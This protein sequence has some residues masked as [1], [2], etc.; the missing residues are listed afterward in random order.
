MSSFYVSAPR[1]VNNLNFAGH[2]REPMRYWIVVIQSLV[3]S[4]T[5]CLLQESQNGEKGGTKLGTTIIRFDSTRPRSKDQSQGWNTLADKQTRTLGRNGKDCT[6]K[7]FSISVLQLE[8]KGKVNFFSHQSW[9]GRYVEKYR[10][11]FKNISIRQNIAQKISI[12]QYI[13]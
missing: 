1:D 9:P 10:Y 2:L 3:T 13:V 6:K 8:W 12:R 7:S 5:S 4:Y 11:T